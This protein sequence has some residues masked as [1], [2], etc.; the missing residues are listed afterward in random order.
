MSL[1]RHF[2]SKD[3]LI[4]AY[5]EDLR[6]HLWEWFDDATVD[7]EDP[8]EQL[9]AIFAATER[10]TTNPE[11]LGCSFQSTTAEFPD[12]DHPAHRIAVAHNHPSGDPAPS[13]DDIAMTEALIEA[14]AL[15][16]IDVLDHIVFGHGRYVSMRE[17]H[18]GFD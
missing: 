16:N 4:V 9:V 5:L 7:I 17:Q 18:L 3:E 10:L 14:G 8:T 11:F 6:H 2:A 12:P 15:L 13:S 1:Y